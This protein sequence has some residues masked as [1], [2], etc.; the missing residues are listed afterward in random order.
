M[1]NQQYR[2]K[3]PIGTVLWRMTGKYRDGKVYWY[4]DACS[5]EQHTSEGFGFG[6]EPNPCG[7][8]W[9]AIGKVYFLSRDD[10][11]LTWGDKPFIEDY[12]IPKEEQT[13]H[14]LKKYGNHVIYLEN[15]VTVLS[16]TIGLFKISLEPEELAWN[17]DG[18]SYD[19]E[20]IHNWWLTLDEI[21][22]Q[23]WKK[24]GIVTI[25]VREEDPLGG[26]IYKVENDG[27]WY[28][29]GATMGYA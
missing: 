24:N 26:I 13:L 14:D 21:R 27:L 11:F 22:E 1:T 12:S 8:S 4:P 2:E 5:I 19:I 16:I 15:G 3:Y 23:I 6:I 10:C 9:N 25:E 7:A 17:T 18:K 28:K 29:H 20:D